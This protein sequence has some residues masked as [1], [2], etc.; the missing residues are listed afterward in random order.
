MPAPSRLPGGRLTLWAVGRAPRSGVS[1]KSMAGRASTSWGL[2]RF[3]LEENLRRGCMAPKSG[4]PLGCGQRGPLCLCPVCSLFL[5]KN[6]AH[7]WCRGVRWGLLE[8]WFSDVLVSVS[9]YTLKNYREAQRVLFMWLY[10]SILKTNA[11]AKLKVLPV[12]K[13]GQFEQQ[14]SFG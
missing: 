11:G 1:W 2:V 14:N 7:T 6:H 10:I 5:R 4:C 3:R 13:T 12:A 9:L 8:Q